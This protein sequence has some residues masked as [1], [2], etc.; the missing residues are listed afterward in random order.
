MSALNKCK[1]LLIAH[2][3]QCSISQNGYNRNETLGA[4]I[5]SQAHRAG[6]YI[7]T[8][9]T[10]TQLKSKLVTTRANQKAFTVTLIKIF[11]PRFLS[12]PHTHHPQSLLSR[13]RSPLLIPMRHPKDPKTTL[14]HMTASISRAVSS[15]SHI[16]SI[17]S[18]ST[19]AL[20]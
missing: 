4:R 11:S 19:K 2:C 14:V 7:H 8:P 12:A 13:Q 5:F 1:F 10:K 15:T 9:R 6:M 18:L 3:I 16:T 20:I 17:S